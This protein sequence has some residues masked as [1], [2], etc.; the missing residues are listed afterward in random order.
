MVAAINA[1][2]ARI[3]SAADMRGRIIEQGFLP[4][5]MGVA[6]TER[7]VAGD[8]ARWAKVTREANIK[9]D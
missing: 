9:A 1:E 5:T 7:F 4:V 2:V 3:T 8:V 6:E